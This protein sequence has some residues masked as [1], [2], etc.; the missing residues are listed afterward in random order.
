MLRRALLLIA[1]AFVLIPVRAGAQ[2]WAEYRPPGGGFSLEMPGE[3][4][5]EVMN[6]DTAIGQVKG[7]TATVEVGGVGYMSMYI[8]YPPDRVRGRPITPMLDGARNGAVANV[9]GQ[10]HSEEQVMVDNHPGRQIIIDAPN[11]MVLVQKFFVLDATL[12]QAIVGGHPGVEK[13]P[14]TIRFL[15]SLKVV[16][17]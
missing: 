10:L 7:Y 16:A 2:T 15:Q 8:P 17:P 14:N 9:H 12:I 3:W 6:I 1:I 13:D 11:D 4:T 5:T